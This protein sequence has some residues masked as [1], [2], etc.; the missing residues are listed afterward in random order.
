MGTFPIR[1]AE[2]TKFLL[3][4]ALN[5]RYCDFVGILVRNDRF[6]CGKICA[7]RVKTREKCGFAGVALLWNCL[8]QIVGVERAVHMCGAVKIDQK[9]L[10]LHARG[11][12]LAC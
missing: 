9:L 12:R 4:M 8:R 2:G 10:L 1:H 6:H 3:S 7:K 5:A 11:R